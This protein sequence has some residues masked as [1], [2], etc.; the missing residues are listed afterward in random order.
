MPRPWRGALLVL[1]TGLGV[2]V[3]AHDALAAPRDYASHYERGWR[4]LPPPRASWMAACH[5]LATGSRVPGRRRRQTRRWQALL[6]ARSG[7]GG[8]RIPCAQRGCC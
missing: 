7:A 8:H 2:R 6:G 4:H 5:R 1:T 3:A